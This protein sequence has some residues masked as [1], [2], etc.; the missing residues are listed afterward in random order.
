VT[1]QAGAG[2]TRST[3]SNRSIGWVPL[4]SVSFVVVPIDGW[5]RQLELAGGPHR[6]PA[7]PRLTASPG[8]VIWRPARRRPI[9]PVGRAMAKVQA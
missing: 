4:A 8:Y 9:K 2:T 1:V 3:R 6:L 5:L 7:K